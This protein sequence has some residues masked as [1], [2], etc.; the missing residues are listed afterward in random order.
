MHIDH[1]QSVDEFQEI[2][3]KGLNE[4]LSAQYDLLERR[5]ISSISIEKFNNQGNSAEREHEL[6]SNEVTLEFPRYK[7][8]EDSIFERERSQRS[9]MINHQN[10]PLV[11]TY[12]EEPRIG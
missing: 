7:R 8:N 9:M 4:K 12:K 3:K 10:A 6:N 2:I 11:N 5:I 1:L